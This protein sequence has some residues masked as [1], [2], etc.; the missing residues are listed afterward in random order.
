MNKIILFD[1]IKEMAIKDSTG[2]V[3]ITKTYLVTLGKQKSV[4]QNE[5]YQAEQ[6]GLRPQGIIEMCSFDYDGEK[7]LRIDNKE[8]VIYRTYE[9]GTD[10]IELYY[11][12]KVGN[13]NG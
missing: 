2:Q 12:E 1:L 4:Y 3:K 10:K 11:S 5:F 13:N 9:V 8:Y 6:A 7:S